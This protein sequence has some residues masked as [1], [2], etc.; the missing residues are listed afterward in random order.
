[1]STALLFPPETARPQSEVVS[2][3]P[4]WPDGLVLMVLM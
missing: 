4:D 2:C 1:M 3:S